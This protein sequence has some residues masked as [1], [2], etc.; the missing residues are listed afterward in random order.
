MATPENQAKI[1]QLMAYRNARFSCMA[2]TNEIER[3]REL[4]EKITVSFNGMPGVAEPGAKVGTAASILADLERDFQDQLERLH[5]T[6]Q[7]VTE[8]IDTLEREDLKG[9]LRLRYINGFKWS[10][11]ADMVGYDVRHVTRLHGVALALLPS[12]EEL[13]KKM[14]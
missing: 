7:G 3:T 1:E 13:E 2:L 8:A 9:I 12:A 10:T 5:R 4:G 6:Q 11:I 14:S